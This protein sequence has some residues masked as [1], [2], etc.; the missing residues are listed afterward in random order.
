MGVP[1]VT[2]PAPSSKVPDRMRTVSLL[3]L[4]VTKR[5]PPGFRW[6][7]QGW[8]SASVRGIREGQPSMTQPMAGP[9]LSPQVVTRNRWPKLLWDMALWP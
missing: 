7:S 3:R 1:V 9:W 6:S 2:G 8:M 5:L 4:W